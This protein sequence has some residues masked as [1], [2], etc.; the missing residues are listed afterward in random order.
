MEAGLGL[1]L[2][3]IVFMVAG[4]CRY[5]GERLDGEFELLDDGAEVGEILLAGGFFLIG[6]G[7]GNAGNFDAFG[8]G[9]EMRAGCPPVDG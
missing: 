2:E 6:A 5:L 8:A 3:L 4:D 7:D 9:E 1:D